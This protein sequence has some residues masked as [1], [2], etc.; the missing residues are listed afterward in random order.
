MLW[1]AFNCLY[2]Y[3]ANSYADFEG[4]RVFRNFI[5][6]NPNVFT[7]SIGVT[8]SYSQ[9]IWDSFRWR[10]LILNDYKTQN[11]AIALKDFVH[12]YYDSQIMFSLNN[13]ISVREG[14]LNNANYGTL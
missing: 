5:L 12:R 2:R 3:Q 13:V 4:Q 8:S 11:K 10:A 1:R 14:Y 7:N 6:N 9:E